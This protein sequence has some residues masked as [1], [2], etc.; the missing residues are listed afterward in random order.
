MKSIFTGYIYLLL[1]EKNIFYERSE[2]Y[3]SIVYG[4]MDADI[5]T[6]IGPPTCRPGLIK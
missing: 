1:I 6:C 3:D 4:D 2:I 5:L